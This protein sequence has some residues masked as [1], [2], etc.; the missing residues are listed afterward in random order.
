MACPF[1]FAMRGKERYRGNAIGTP[2]AKR[3][4]EI[5]GINIV[6]SDE[7]RTPVYRILCP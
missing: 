6:V 3:V 4:Q 7:L 2:H 1:R 5:E